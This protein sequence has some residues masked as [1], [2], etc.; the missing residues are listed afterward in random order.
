ME[1]RQSTA[2]RRPGNVLDAD[3]RASRGGFHVALFALLYIFRKSD[4]LTNQQFVPP[5]KL[6]PQVRSGC[7]FGLLPK[8]M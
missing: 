4:A 6:L 1:M 3:W 7:A 5:H 8:G 2:N